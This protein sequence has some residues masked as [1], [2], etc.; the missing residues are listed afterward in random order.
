MF[1][2]NEKNLE[3]RRNSVL[4]SVNKRSPAE[5]EGERGRSEGMERE[6][7]KMAKVIE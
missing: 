5:I 2:S 7:V 4:V 6:R 1:S 3:R